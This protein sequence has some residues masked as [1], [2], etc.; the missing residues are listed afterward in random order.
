[1]IKTIYRHLCIECRH[2][3]DTEE[4][5]EKVCPHCE[6]KQDYGFERLTRDFWRGRC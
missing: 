4:L 1:M 2:Q 5:K 3:W 6:A